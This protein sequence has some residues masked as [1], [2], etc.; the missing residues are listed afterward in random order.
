M[1]AASRIALLI[2]D[3]NQDPGYTHNDNFYRVIMVSPMETEWGLP[4]NAPL[5]VL[6]FSKVPQARD[7][8]CPHDASITVIFNCHQKKH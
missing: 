7:A 6:G 2:T 5:C 4:F 8:C 3:L 1:D